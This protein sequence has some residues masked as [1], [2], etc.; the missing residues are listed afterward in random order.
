M[1][2]LNQQS[3]LSFPIICSAVWV[4]QENYL[5]G[6]ALPKSKLTHSVQLLVSS[7]EAFSIYLGL[8]PQVFVYIAYVSSQTYLTFF[9]VSSGI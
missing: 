9:S 3:S 2:N 7:V 6:A 8:N 1:L 5:V 4:A